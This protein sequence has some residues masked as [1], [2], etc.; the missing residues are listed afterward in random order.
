MKDNE[1][2]FIGK[3]F[4]LPNKTFYNKV[5]PLLFASLIRWGVLNRVKYFSYVPWWLFFG[6]LCYYYVPPRWQGQCYN[7]G[8]AKN[9][10]TV[11]N[12]DMLKIGHISHTVDKE[13]HWYEQSSYQVSNGTT[14]QNNKFSCEYQLFS[15]V[16]LARCY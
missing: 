16:S 1:V 13:E 8:M 10:G 11:C 4:S 7:Q 2:V 14:P 5:L 15:L 6:Y 9:G 12:Y 3:A